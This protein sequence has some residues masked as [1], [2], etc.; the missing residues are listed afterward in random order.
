M[1][2][3]QLLPAWMRHLDP[4]VSAESPALT[5][6]RDR[7]VEPPEGRLRS[8]GAVVNTAGMTVI[9]MAFVAM[10]A[11]RPLMGAF[12]WRI[13]M[14][15]FMAVMLLLVVMNKTRW[16]LDRTS[17]ITLRNAVR[18][19]PASLLRELYVAGIGGSDILVGLYRECMPR[20]V[21]GY[22]LAGFSLAAL[23]V[24]PYIAFSGPP[25]YLLPL[26]A[27]TCILGVGL[28]LLIRSIMMEFVIET[29][30]RAT[31]NRWYGP[32]TGLYPIPFLSIVAWSFLTSIMSSHTSVFVT[33]HSA[34]LIVGGCI[35]LLFFSGLAVAGALL[36][37]L[38]N[39]GAVRDL[40]VV[41]DSGFDQYIQR[42]ADKAL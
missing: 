23:C 17:R 6:L 29:E 5:A 31:V 25:W 27:C 13:H 11:M 2:I 39:R 3:E 28:T 19:H 16:L 36:I 30:L 9:I 20:R 37:A 7:A 41:A 15:L 14:A 40:L 42:E 24:L 22:A 35:A 8:F 1:N 34:R 33:G 4:L 38:K 26:I 18:G 12:N 10:H 21:E 32:G